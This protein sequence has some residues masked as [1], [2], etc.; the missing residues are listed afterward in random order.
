MSIV[1]SLNYSLFEDDE[2]AKMIDTEGQ[3]AM[4][5]FYLEDSDP[6]SADETAPELAD[7]PVFVRNLRH[8]MGAA[9]AEG[10]YE[11]DLADGK[12]ELLVEASSLA[13]SGN[14]SYIFAKK[15]QLDG[16]ANGIV[17]KI[18]FIPI[19]LE[20][21]AAAETD[22][23]YYQKLANDT[24]EVVS[25]DSL[26]FVEGPVTVYEKVAY[27]IVSEPGYYFAK[28]RNSVSGKKA[29]SKESDMLYIP[30]AS[31][32]EIK[33]EMPKRFVIKEAE[34]SLAKNET[35]DQSQ[36]PGAQQSNIQVQAGEVGPAAITLGAAEVGPVFEAAK[37]AGLSYE[38]FKSEALDAEGHMVEPVSISTSGPELEVT[39]PG[40]YA[41]KVVNSFNNDTE[42]IDKEAAGIIRVTAMPEVP[43]V[44][45]EDWTKT[46]VSGDPSTKIEIAEPAAYDEVSYEWHMVTGDN[47][48][49]DPIAEGYM[50]D[51]A[52]KIEFTEG[53]GVIPFHPL[54]AGFYY[55]IVKNELN[56]A[57]ILM[58]SG[59]QFG[60]IYVATGS[61]APVNP[62]PTP[63]PEPSDE[64]ADVIDGGEAGNGGEGQVDGGETNEGQ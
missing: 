45:F 39:E 4:I 25:V 32:P 16:G 35:I 6:D 13:D 23:I 36:M 7:V 48:D 2:A 24:F 44:L 63:Q 40:Y 61:N 56:E 22:R 64:P 17:A 49:M 50:A 47:A 62:T 28:A 21:A 27:A 15:D 3:G 41:V 14:I 1:D 54:A 20:S 51:A 60:T 26:D 34:Y 42:E 5:L 12:L 30:Y 18:K 59:E 38:W 53:K 55:F 33:K 11:A 8:I 31:A 43:E 29:S 52:G 46:V 9:E 10:L 37:S 19:E 57:S 58:N